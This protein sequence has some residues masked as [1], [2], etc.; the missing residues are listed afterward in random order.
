MVDIM[1][2]RVVFI[3][4]D[5]QLVRE[6]LV[7]VDHPRLHILKGRQVS[8]FLAFQVGGVEP[9]VLVAAHILQVQDV[10]VIGG[11]GV[12]TDAAFYI[13]GDGSVIILPN[14]S[15]PDIQ[16]VVHRGKIGH[17]PAVRRNLWA[18]LDGIAK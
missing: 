5:E 8:C 15:H 17:P 6:M 2:L 16:D 10:F 3:H 14:R 7:P 11:P 1:H 4:P 12:K 9:P 18:G 13:I